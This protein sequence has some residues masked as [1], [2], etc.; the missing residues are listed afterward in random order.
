[1][2]LTA[3]PVWHVA[4]LNLYANP[5]LFAGGTVL[6]MQAF[7]PGLALDL[8]TRAEDPVTHFTGVPAHYQFIQARPGW[9]EARTSPRS[10]PGSVGRRFPAALVERGGGAVSPCAASTGSARPARA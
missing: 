4:G 6:V 8:L 7:D 5:V 3:L 9:A 1:M 2:C 10:W